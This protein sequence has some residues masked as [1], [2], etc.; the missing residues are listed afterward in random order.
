MQTGGGGGD[1]Q[2]GKGFLGGG[3]RI[4]CRAGEGYVLS[5]AA[6]SQAGPHDLPNLQKKMVWIS[7]SA[8]K[9]VSYLLH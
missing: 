1:T 7:V 3:V 2:G 5:K 9:S 8:R 4:S 6:Q